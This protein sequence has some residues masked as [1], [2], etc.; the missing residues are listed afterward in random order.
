MAPDRVSAYALTQGDNPSARV[1]IHLFLGWAGGILCYDKLISLVYG[2]LVFL[3]HLLDQIGDARSLAQNIV[4]TVREPLLVL[5]GELEILFASTSFHRAFQIG[6]ENTQNR[7][8]FALDNGAWDI[9]ALRLLLEQAIFEQ[10]VLEGFEVAHEFPRIGRRI[11]LLHARRALYKENASAIILLAFEDVTERRLIEQERA[12]LQK[13]TDDLLRQKEVL[14]KRCSIV[15]ST[16]CR[17]SP[18]FSC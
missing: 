9:P 3:K 7:L 14:L 13:Q 16:A 15:S 6:A 17:S 2:R 18:V 5:N 4:D 1:S 12:S 11:L 10:A 8:M